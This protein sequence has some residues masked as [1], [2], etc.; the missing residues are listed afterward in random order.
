MKKIVFLLLLFVCN[1]CLG[2]ELPPQS[3]PSTLK[4]NGQ[5]LTQDITIPV[6]LVLIASATSVSGST[7]A[8]TALTYAA[9]ISLATFIPTLVVFKYVSG[10]LGICVSKIQDGSGNSL[11]TV[12]L[13]NVTSSQVVIA[14]LSGAVSNSGNIF[15]NVTTASLAASSMNV[16]VYGTSRP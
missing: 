10:T 3:V 8:S 12:A 11:A 9:S 14:Q 15:V 1:F 16:Y 6:G 7:L 13:Q 2:Q 5:T 4:I